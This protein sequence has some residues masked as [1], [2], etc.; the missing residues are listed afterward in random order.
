VPPRVHAERQLCAQRQR[1]G[2][3]EGRGRA[4]PHR[5]VRDRAGAR[6]R[7]LRRVQR[8]APEACGRH[9]QERGQAAPPHAR[10]QERGRGALAREG[11][12]H[13]PPLD[14][15]APLHRAS[16]AAGARRRRPPV[17]PPAQRPRDSAPRPPRRIRQ[18][19]GRPVAQPHGRR[20]L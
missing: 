4:P 10:L 15:R 14:G 13:A 12:R 19:P 18:R 11:R 17:H 3:H 2:P 16:R 9:L 1:P 6:L 8:R 7:P 5:Q 20:G